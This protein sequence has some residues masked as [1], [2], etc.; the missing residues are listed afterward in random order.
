M[1]E[2]EGPTPALPSIPV[3]ANSMQ[4][5]PPLLRRG[6]P[7]GKVGCGR[8]LLPWKVQCEASGFPTTPGGSV[9][10]EGA[11]D[12][13]SDPGVLCPGSVLVKAVGVFS[14]CEG[15]APPTCSLAYLVWD[16]D[17]DDVELTGC[18]GF[19]FSLGNPKSSAEFRTNGPGDSNPT[20]RGPPG[21]WVSGQ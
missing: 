9:P 13:G 8:W 3:V 15:V 19:Q 20:A 17:N 5:P 7:A 11:E 14:V 12:Q 2:W 10:E 16:C 18:F 6:A 1:N 21:C 4:M